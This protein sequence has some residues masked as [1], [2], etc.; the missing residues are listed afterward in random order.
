M[1]EQ[2][3]SLALSFWFA[4][5]PPK[6]SMMEKEVDILKRT[7]FSNVGNFSFVVAKLLHRRLRLVQA[8]FVREQMS[9]F[10]NGNVCFAGKFLEILR[11]LQLALSI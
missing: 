4:S 9:Q 10:E 6:V 5:E 7:L 11:A 8:T 1:D 3:F 2:A